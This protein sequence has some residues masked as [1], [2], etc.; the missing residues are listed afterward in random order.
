MTSWEIEPL[1]HHGEQHYVHLRV[2][3]RR[4][5]HHGHQ[6][7]C[8]CTASRHSRHVNSSSAIGLWRAPHDHSG[9][10]P[11]GKTTAY[12]IACSR[13]HEC[14]LFRLLYNLCSAAVPTGSVRIS[15]MIQPGLGDNGTFPPCPPQR[16]NLQQDLLLRPVEP[17]LQHVRASR[18]LR[19]HR[20]LLDV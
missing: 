6:Q 13:P 11:H 4:P 7:P 3:Y 15:P 14:E 20:P 12:N 10:W 16:A 17:P 9:Q 2:Q 8:R 19:L 5:P 1:S 18:P